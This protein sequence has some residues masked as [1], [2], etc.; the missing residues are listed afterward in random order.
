MKLEEV[1]PNKPV[2]LLIGPAG[3]GKTTFALQFRKPYL[4]NVDNNLAGPRNYFKRAGISMDGVNYDN[5]AFDDAGAPIQIKDQYQRFTS[6]LS[7]AV[8]DAN[9]STIIID[10]TTSMQSVLEAYVVTKR[11]KPVGTKFTFDEWFDF[12]YIWSETITK[13]RGCGKTVIIIGHEQV[14]KGEIDQV[15]RYVLAIPGKTGD[16]MPMLVTDVWRMSVELKLVGTQQKGYYSVTTIQDSRRPNIKTS[17]TLP[18]S[19]EASPANV[20]VIENQIYPE[21]K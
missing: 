18:T 14:E 20:V 6:L 11:G 12:Q 17:F 10:S 15:L 9:T 8:Q 21:S 3:C 4:I 1:V 2:I 13:L 5:V 19:F 7:R 16:L